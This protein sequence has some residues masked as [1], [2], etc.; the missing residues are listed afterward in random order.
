[1]TSRVRFAYAGWVVAAAVTATAGLV[2]LD[3]LRRPAATA[4]EKAAAAN[5]PVLV[6][7]KIGGGGAA[8]TRTIQ[9]AIDLA[10]RGA[11]VSV[12]PGTY[13][14]PLVIRRGLTL[15][16]TGETT[17][18]AIIAPLG[19]PD[20]VI[21]IATPDAV[22]IRGVTIH[23]SGRSAIRAV[24]EVNLTVERTSVQA[25]SPASDQKALI[26]VE[27]DARKSGARAK[28]TIRQSRI[29]GAVAVLPRGMART[30]NSAVEFA[31]DVD[32]VFDSNTVRRTGAICV[33][34]STL[35]DFTGH[36]VVDILNNDIDE[37]HPM[38]RVGAIKV[39]SPAVG[40]LS[41]RLPVTA[42]GTVNVIGNTIKNSS[43][44][45]V[46]SAIAY[47]VF[48]GRIER[49]R[50]IDFVQSCA[51]GNPR[52]LPGAIWLGLRPAIKVPAAT[53]V[54]QFN[55]IQGNAHAGLRLGPNQALPTVVRCNYWGSAKGPSGTGPGDGDAI[56]VESGTPAPAFLPF[57]KSPVAQ[58]PKPPC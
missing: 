14:E 41:P 58:A 19:A 7:P 42:T 23:A 37:C 35:D 31:G 5:P 15:E 18:A 25:V 33:V 29:D 27:N 9:E 52:N 51:T 1:M 46:N 3:A 30:Q 4:P 56:V 11:T 17:G 44:D 39:G 43:R 26:V 38:G 48:A 36:T 57:A 32:A 8:T 16:A 34:V 47:D 20:A 24:G 45:C 6:K 49:N 53:P 21:E 54:V 2:M 12:L 28:A 22:I 13:A 10:V 40:L 50:I 55:D